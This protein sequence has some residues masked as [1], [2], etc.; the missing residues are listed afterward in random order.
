MKIIS[1]VGR[2][3]GIAKTT[4]ATNLAVAASKSGY[5]TAL[6][7]LDPQASAAMWDDRRT[8]E[9]VGPTTTSVATP[10]LAKVLEHCRQAGAGLVV[11]DTGANTDAAALA[12]A[13]AVDLVLAP[14]GPNALD[15]TA[16][17]ATRDL[18]LTAGCLQKS[19]GVVTRV[20][21]TP[22]HQAGAR[23]VLGV[24][25]KLGMASTDRWMCT[26]STYNYAAQLGQ[27]AIE[28]EPEGK[29]AAEVWAIWQ[30]AAE[31]LG[32]PTQVETEAVHA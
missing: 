23:E 17:P 24:F 1:I 11:I 30:V 15:I 29:A 25:E 28:Y 8:T 13:K 22:S 21:A 19:L 18:L 31:L 3:G 2:K 20:P 9:S 10:R 4:L 14:C 12:A 27:A 16:L 7:D 5:E 32:I 26:R 6:L